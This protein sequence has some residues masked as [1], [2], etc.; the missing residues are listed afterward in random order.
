MSN[1][2]SFLTFVKHR[3]NDKVLQIPM[4]SAASCAK[5][6]GPRRRNHTL[7][8]E[9]KILPIWNALKTWDRSAFPHANSFLHGSVLCLARAAFWGWLTADAHADCVGSWAPV[10][11]THPRMPRSSDRPPTSLQ[12]AKTCCHTRPDKKHHKATEVLSMLRKEEACRK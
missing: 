10:A 3:S 9:N 1:H 11:A 2:H 12:R 6:T 8:F 5:F 7:F 4:Q